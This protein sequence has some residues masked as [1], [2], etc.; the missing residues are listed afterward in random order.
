VRGPAGQ[1]QR[2]RP[3]SSRWTAGPASAEA[4]AVEGFEHR[5]DDQPAVARH[6]DVGAA[7]LAELGRVD[8]DVDHLGFGGE[9][10]DATG[11]PVVETAAEGD[12]QVGAL[13][14]GDRR[15]VAVHPRHTEAQR[16][17]VGERTA[18][19]EGGHD[20]DAG[21]LGELKQRAVGLCLQDA[22]TGVDDRALGGEQQL[23]ARRMRAGSP[24]VTGL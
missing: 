10:V 17:R 1:R 16:V 14:G 24:T 19:H 23:G 7:H 12:E 15:V 11:D 4:E 6:A 2:I 3:A 13:H 5:L 21:A 18:R 9:G 20:R 8:V 22:T